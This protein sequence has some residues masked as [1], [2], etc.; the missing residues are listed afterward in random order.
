MPQTS[1][2]KQP[3]KTARTDAKGAGSTVEVNVPDIPELQEGDQ[4]NRYPI[5][6]VEVNVPYKREL[7]VVNFGAHI[8]IRLTPAQTNALRRV[9]EAL[10]ESKATLKTGRRV[11]SLGDAMKHILETI[12]P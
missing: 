4:G 10:D 12:E 1:P 6:T 9:R 2:A 8:D 7:Q 5:E 11:V 3:K